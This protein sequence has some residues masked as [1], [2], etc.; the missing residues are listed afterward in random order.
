MAQAN[1][2]V[3]NAMVIPQEDL[4]RYETEQPKYTLVGRGLQNFYFIKELKNGQFEDKSITVHMVN[5]ISPP[6]R[7]ANTYS[8]LDTIG[9]TAQFGLP[10]QPPP[11]VKKPLQISDIFN[12]A[13]FTLVS[14]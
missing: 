13:S 7:Q 9:K 4:H 12:Y 10:V 8:I 3:N 14:R 2:Q 11:V 1:V 5:P 6:V